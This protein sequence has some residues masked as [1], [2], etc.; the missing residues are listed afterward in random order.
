MKWSMIPCNLPEKITDRDS[1]ILRPKHTY[2]LDK[3]VLFATN[4]IIKFNWNLDYP[5][6][7]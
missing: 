5:I 2:Y 6:N 3:N 7:T 4:Q 1:L